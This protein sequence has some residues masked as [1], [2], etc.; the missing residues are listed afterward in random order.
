MLPIRYSVDSLLPVSDL[1]SIAMLVHSALATAAFGE[2]ADPQTGAFEPEPLDIQILGSRLHLFRRR[3]QRKQYL[4]RVGQPL[5]SLYLVHAG[6]FKAC[7]LSEDGREKITGFRMRGDWLGIDALGT[8]SYTCDAV[9]LDVGE[10]WDV[11]CSQ[12]P[13]F[14]ARL[15][16]LQEHLTAAMAGEIRRDWRW[17]LSLGTLNAEQ[18]VA[19]FL[20]D[21]AARQRTLG[22]SARQLRL[23]MTRAEIGNFLALQ[24][25]TV[26]RALSRFG[27]LGII[28]VERREIRLNDPD[29][30]QMLLATARTCH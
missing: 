10:V 4:F 1:E 7:V 24:L 23:R 15:P 27:E 20:L 22:F 19:A 8:S 11:P 17:M 6:F 18:R 12:L 5:H 26:T 21:M 28:G 16:Q 3:I 13:V 25:E 14:C 9:A 30:L 29:A 2:R